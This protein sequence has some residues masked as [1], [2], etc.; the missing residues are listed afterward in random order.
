MVRAQCRTHACMLLHI[1]R[2]FKAE[3]WGPD[4]GPSHVAEGFGQ[5]IRLPAPGILNRL[6]APDS[7]S[8]REQKLVKSRNAMELNKFDDLL[9]F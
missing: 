2:V 9:G 7:T 3:L 8:L 6:P 5:G 1:C 4:L